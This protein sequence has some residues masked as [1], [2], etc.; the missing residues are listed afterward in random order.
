[1]IELL[2]KQCKCEL[3]IYKK[4]LNNANDSKQTHEEGKALSYTASRI[5]LDSSL[6]FTT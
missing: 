4:L 3:I 2:L 1:M 5:F 6:Y